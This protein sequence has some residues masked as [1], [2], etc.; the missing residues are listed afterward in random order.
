MLWF[1]EKNRCCKNICNVAGL[2]FIVHL[3][4]LLDF[5]CYSTV[6]SKLKKDN[7]KRR[8]DDNADFSAEELKKSYLEE[9]Q[10]V[11]V[12]TYSKVDVDKIKKSSNYINAAAKKGIASC[13][14]IV[15]IRGKT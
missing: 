11:R 14:E 7:C 5:I 13:Y 2:P 8:R 15:I 6:K 9:D 10:N 12:I 4:F 3:E 1:W